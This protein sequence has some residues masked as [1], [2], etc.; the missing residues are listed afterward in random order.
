MI[1]QDCQEQFAKFGFSQRVAE[2]FGQRKTSEEEKCTKDYHQFFFS[3]SMVTAS[4][5]LPVP[6]TL[7]HGIDAR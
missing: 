5:S 6:R 1:S 7:V 4:N 3:V 2:C